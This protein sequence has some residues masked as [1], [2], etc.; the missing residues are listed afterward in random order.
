[1][2]ST[3][4]FE[5]SGHGTVNFDPYVSRAIT[6]GSYGG[7]TLY[8]TSTTV[9]LF[10]VGAGGADAPG[11][12][13]SSFASAVESA[14]G[15]SQGALSM[16]S[17]ASP[18]GASNLEQ[19]AVADATPAGTGSVD[20][21][22]VTYYDVT[23]DMTKLADTPDLT[24]VQRVTIEA[25][26]PLLRQ[27]GYTGTTERIGVDDAAYIRE[28]T[29]TNH[30]NDGSTGVR[31]TVLSN[32]GCAAKIAL[33]GQSDP[34]VETTQ[35]CAPPPTTTSVPPTTTTSRP[36]ASTTTSSLAPTATS[37]PST[38]TR[39]PPTTLDPGP[40]PSSTGASR[41]QYACWTSSGVGMSPPPQPGISCW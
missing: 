15:P 38:T 33:P 13:L 36:P 37:A 24:D 28:V 29:A 8:V 12:P 1:M 26:L 6:N 27:G 31:H 21:V 41:G 2:S 17:L 14:L 25:A 10:G 35:P 32:F 3:S 30:F 22:S 40:P 23:I 18:G 5:S 19:E 9:W 39:P 16:I 20:G 7:R 34:P 11:M 4:T